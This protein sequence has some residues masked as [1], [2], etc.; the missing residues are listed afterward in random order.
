MLIRPL[1]IPEKG[2]FV[3]PP[4]WETP[5]RL[6]PIFFFLFIGLTLLVRKGKLSGM[7]HPLRGRLPFIAGGWIVV[8]A[9]PFF[10]HPLSFE[11][12]NRYLYRH[13]LRYGAEHKEVTFSGPLR[14]LWPSSFIPPLRLR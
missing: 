8:T 1:V 9:L 11:H 3:T 2:I 5:L 13:Y 6:A 10:L 12:A 4:G 7:V 14:E